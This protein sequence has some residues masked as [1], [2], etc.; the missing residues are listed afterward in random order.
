MSKQEKTRIRTA[1]LFGIHW[2]RVI[3]QACLLLIM[4]LVSPSLS[5]AGMLS[6]QD[7][8]YTVVKG[9]TFSSI[10][11]AFGV[12]WREIAMDNGL[13]PSRELRAGRKL[14]ITAS[15]IIP[16]TTQTGIFIDIPGR[17]LYLFD[18]GIPLMAV[19]VGLG[20]PRSDG[21]RGWETPEGT[22]TIKGRLKN[23]DWAVPKSIQEEM[24]REGLAA[25]ESYPPGPKNPVGGYVLLT[26]IPGILIHETIDPLSV[27][28][29]LSHGCVRVLAKD[30]EQL[31][32]YA[33]S[34]MAGEIV[35]APIKIAS[36]SN[37]RVFIEV[38]KDVYGKIKDMQ[39]EALRLLKNS[40]LTGKVDLTKLAKAVQE[41]TGIPADVTAR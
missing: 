24:R 14:R 35:Y 32:G 30:M 38:N 29:F 8:S 18:R 34:G 4:I 22:F 27:S 28:R 9:D 17:M 26:T 2:R 40:N 6:Q 7:I 41:Q 5:F 20:K 25:K 13:D 19:P 16:E 11:S 12:D 39:A 23:P 15:R 1:P 37:G 36:L 3:L 31:F 33:V 10:G 21:N